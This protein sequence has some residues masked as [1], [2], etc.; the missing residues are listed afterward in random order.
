MP[1]LLTV[2][3]RSSFG[4]HT[5]TCHLSDGVKELRSLQEPRQARGLCLN[6]FRGQ[7]HRAFSPFGAGSVSE[8]LLY[9]R[10]ARLGALGE[11]FGMCG[12]L[13]NKLLVCGLS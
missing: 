6:T 8:P 10:V 7:Q 12:V 13:L 3:Q 9:E 1:F 4:H 11:S 2:S 5:M